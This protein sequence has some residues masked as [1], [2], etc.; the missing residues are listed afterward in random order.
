MT[1]TTSVKDTPDIVIC[2]E[3]YRAWEIATTP[4]NRCCVWKW[5]LSRVEL[6]GK[7]N[8]EPLESQVPQDELHITLSEGAEYE[9]R[10]V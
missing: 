7:V 5:F 4:S 10:S 2:L 6:T 1:L 9:I 8:L 3:V